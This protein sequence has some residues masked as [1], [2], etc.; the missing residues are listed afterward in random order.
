MSAGNPRNEL[1]C[2]K[3][4]LTIT[5]SPSETI[6]NLYQLKTKPEVIRYLHAAAGFP[7]KAT[8]YNAV[9]MVIIT[10]GLG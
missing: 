1:G 4:L 6:A 5:P 9:K 2:P 8:W 3:I 10:H 7:T